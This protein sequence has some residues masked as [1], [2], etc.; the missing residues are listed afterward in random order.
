VT[1]F[2]VIAGLSGAG[3]STVADTLED[4]GWFVI[5]NLPTPLIPKVAEL[6]IVPESSIEKVALALGSSALPQDIL[7]ALADLRTGPARVRVLFL[8]AS[9]DTLVRRYE[10]TKRR[11]PRSSGEQLVES[12]E[13][14]R[15][16]LE[17]V[18][19][20]ADVIVDTSH[21][22]IYELRSRVAELFADGEG[23]DHHMQ[24]T[25]L[26]FGY[27]HGLPTDVDIVLDC[28]FLPNPYWVDSL[29]P[30]TGRD[31]QVV[32]YVLGE[33]AAQQFLAR[34]DD[35]LDV[36]LPQYVSEGKAY[37]GIA[38]GCTGGRHRSVAIVEEVAERLRRRGI[39]ATVKHRDVDR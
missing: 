17:P 24:T 1:E 25:L 23:G 14:E 28:R 10:S 32:A 35:L 29:R 4:R 33:D 37:L 36:L 30:L 20:E 34:L 21:L 11:H 15:A 18:K 26:S 5:D 38:F 39:D 13:H 7:P 12:I 31:P 6:A 27:K 9:T 8:E 19:A 3:R 2:A 22:N 16:L